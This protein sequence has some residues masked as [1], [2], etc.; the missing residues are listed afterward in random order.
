M[1]GEHKPVSGSDTAPRPLLYDVPTASR[2]L[3]NLGRTSVYNLMKTGKLHPV[4]IG[5]RTFLTDRE[6]RR[7]VSA[8]EQEAA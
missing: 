8:C 1:N 4:K 3:G 6:L 5:K 7:Y 2:I